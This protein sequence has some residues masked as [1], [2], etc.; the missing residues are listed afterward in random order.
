MSEQVNFLFDGARTF[1]VL[2][3]KLLNEDPD[4]LTTVKT[5]V[6]NNLTDSLKN[7][8]AGNPKTS[9]LAKELIER[10][11]FLS[12]ISSGIPEDTLRV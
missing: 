8:A 9:E 6:E 5:F 11:E 10:I 1:V 3:L 2:V 4:S 12:G 7:L